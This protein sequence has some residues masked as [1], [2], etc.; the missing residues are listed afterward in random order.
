MML[1]QIF[2]FTGLSGAGKTTM[3]NLV[4][5]H[6]RQK[7]YRVLVLD[8]DHV[9]SEL[10]QHLGFSP[11]EIK[12]NNHLIANLCQKHRHETDMILVPIISPYRKSRRLARNMLQPG[13]YEIHFDAD[14]GTLHIRD[15]KGLYRMAQQGK[16]DNLIGVSKKNIYEPPTKPDLYLNTSS[17]PAT[18][19]LEEFINFIDSKMAISDIR[20]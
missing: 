6:Y 11:P 16:I 19:T 5:K 20:F 14:I 18:E 8:G 2:W 15:T 3:A 13:Y 17:Q 12:K 4:K 9:R 1:S 10:H 7:K